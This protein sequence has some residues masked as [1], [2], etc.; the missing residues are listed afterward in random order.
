MRQVKDGATL[1][2][3]ERGRPVAELR[4]LT[5]GGDLEERL[6]RLAA[7]GLVSREVREALP[8]EEFTPIIPS[9]TWPTSLSMSQAVIE[10]REDRL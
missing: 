10:D 5:A 9:P 2:V 8:L 6:Y 3:T 7:E 4:P 1:I